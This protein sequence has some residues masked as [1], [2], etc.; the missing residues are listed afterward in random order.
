MRPHALGVTVAVVVIVACAA[1]CQDQRIRDLERQNYLVRQQRAEL[2]A[3]LAALK[4]ELSDTN[5]GTAAELAQK[6]R[7]LQELQE[8][9]AALVANLQELKEQYE[10]ALNTP[11][12]TF[13]PPEV[14]AELE[15]VSQGLGGD[16]FSLEGNVLRFKSDI[17]FDSG[18][19]EVKPGP[20]A[21][22][23][24]IADI[25]NS[26]EAADLFLRVDGHTD[27]QPIK[28]SK[29]DDNLQLSAERARN[30]LKALMKEGVDP[31]RM[32][33]AA[34]GEYYPRQTN[35]TKEGRQ[36][37]RRVEI[38]LLLEPPIPLARE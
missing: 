22:L 31:C 12:G 5:A 1:G 8:R 2:Q 13:L 30:V 4:A 17:L 35:D 11:V 10:G 3:D 33:L 19:A 29:Y 27:S 7:Q 18:K 16:V 34:F 21:I 24:Q 23:A 28:F 37:N 26:P 25:L 32:Y 15:R 38:Y 36:A 14:V 6:E 9:N 20:R